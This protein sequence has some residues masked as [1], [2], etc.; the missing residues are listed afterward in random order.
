MQKWLH[1]S[2]KNNDKQTG[3]SKNIKYPNM[4]STK[5]LN[6]IIQ[7][8]LKPTIKQMIKKIARHGKHYDQLTHLLYFMKNTTNLFFMYSLDTQ[9]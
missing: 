9:I 4:K 8:K 6:L 5:V 1:Y 3:L 7:W 2:K